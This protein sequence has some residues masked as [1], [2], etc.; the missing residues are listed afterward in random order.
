M[1]MEKILFILGKIQIRFRSD[2]EFLRIEKLHKDRNE[3]QAR[4]LGWDRSFSPRCD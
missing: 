1:A 4:I 2:I 3:E